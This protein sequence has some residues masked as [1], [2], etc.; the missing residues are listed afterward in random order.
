[1]FAVGIIQRTCPGLKPASKMANP[2]QECRRRQWGGGLVVMREDGGWS[3]PAFYDVGGISVGPQVGGAGGAVAF[4]LMDQQ[5]VDAFKRS[6]SFS[7]NAGAGLSIVDYSA[8]SQ[9]SWGKGDTIMWSD[10]AGAYVG[11]TISVTDVEWA[12]VQQPRLSREQRQLVSNSEWERRRCRCSGVEDG[13]TRRV[14]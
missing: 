9:A 14:D 1:M 7:L 6:N 2:R 4:L 13:A 8:N 5:A 12:T 3:D 11:A 10:N